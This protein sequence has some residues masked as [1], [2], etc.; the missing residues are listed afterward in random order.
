MVVGDALF[1]PYHLGYFLKELLRIDAVLHRG[2]PLNLPAPKLVLPIPAEAVLF[3][4]VDDRLRGLLI[5]RELRLPEATA[6]GQVDTGNVVACNAKGIGS[7]FP[8]GLL[9]R[10]IPGLA[11]IGGGV[12]RF[13]FRG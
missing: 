4:L 3:Q 13:C 10:F 9:R 7:E 6:L 12:Y 5:E 8:G 1:L 2:C 11:F